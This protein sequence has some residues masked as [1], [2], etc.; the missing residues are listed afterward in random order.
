M[1][2]FNQSAAVDRE[3]VSH[4]SKVCAQAN[5]IFREF[6]V[7][8]VGIDGEIELVDQDGHPTA[9]LARVQIKSG[10]SYT[11]RKMGSFVFKA[12][13]KH[14]EYWHRHLLPVIGVVYNPDVNKAV[15][16]DI[17][18]QANQVMEYGGL[19]QITAPL[20]PSNEFNVHN[21]STRIRELI[22][23]YH[24]SPV[25]NQE[26]E[27]LIGQLRDSPPSSD[28][29]KEFAWKRLITVFL[30]SVSELD[31]LAEAG[32][33]LSWYFSVAS[34]KHQRLF[35]ERIAHISDNELVRV[36]SAIHSTIANNRPDVGDLICDLLS[37]LSNQ[38]ERLKALGRARAVP[39]E[40]LE[41]LFQAIEYLTQEFQ[42]SFR[43]E[44]S[45][46]YKLSNDEIFREQ[47]V[48]D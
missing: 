18:Q 8:D 32:Y 41:G 5:I 9:M 19:L 7:S 1:T 28:L 13:Q 3:G 36:V 2:I 20:N 15:W 48:N 37:Y 43:K 44:I 6:P 4:V 47:T 24:R 29:E 17:K 26:I 16:F 42:Y 31:T 46:L 23:D 14:Y 40:Y 33:R 22:E 30:S 12:E 38:I 45:A 39:A 25:S 34:E 35:K 10:I 27:I 11:S 21:L